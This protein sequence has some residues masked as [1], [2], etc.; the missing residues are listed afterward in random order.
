[1]I[2]AHRLFVATL[3]TLVLLMLGFAAP[4]PIAA[5]EPNATRL[6]ERP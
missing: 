6:F 1:M 3:A 2:R 4:S 5:N